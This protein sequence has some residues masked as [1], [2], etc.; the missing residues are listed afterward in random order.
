MYKTYYEEA[1]MLKYGFGHSISLE[2]FCHV[3]GFVNFELLH[4]HLTEELKIRGNKS[5]L[6]FNLTHLVNSYYRT[7][8]YSESCEIFKMKHFIKIVKG[9]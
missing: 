2:R 3:D 1:N 9:F 7:Q 5:F 8:A 6:R 4:R